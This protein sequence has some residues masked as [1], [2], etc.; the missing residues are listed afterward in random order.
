[1]EGQGRVTPPKGC[2][3]SPE[4]QTLSPQIRSLPPREWQLFPPR[5]IEILCPSRNTSLQPVEPVFCALNS[6][7]PI[8]VM[9]S[10]YRTGLETLKKAPL[11]SNKK[12]SCNYS[13]ES[14]GSTFLLLSPQVAQ[15]FSANVSK[16]WV[17]VSALPAH[18]AGWVR[19]FICLSLSAAAFG[20]QGDQAG[21]SLKWVPIL[22]LMTL[23]NLFC[24]CCSEN[25]GRGISTEGRLTKS[26]LIFFLRKKNSGCLG[27][28]SCRNYETS[29]F[30]AFCQ[31]GFYLI[32]LRAVPSFNI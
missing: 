16:W 14:T 25:P 22:L 31:P 32:E 11:I 27:I 1:M 26:T 28:S 20:K 29:L 9:M 24:C 30:T 2:S 21:W 13:I 7:K 8:W 3:L 19:H 12:R 5:F 10:Q 17:S 6:R 15:H 4:P 18:R 23:L